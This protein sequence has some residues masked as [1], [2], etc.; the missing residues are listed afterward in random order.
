MY[1]PI[2]PDTMTIGFALKYN[3]GHGEMLESPSLSISKQ[4]KKQ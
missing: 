1:P 3:L 2:P 4:G